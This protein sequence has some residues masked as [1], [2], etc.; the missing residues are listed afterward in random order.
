VPAESVLTAQTSYN[1]LARTILVHRAESLLLQAYRNWLGDD[2]DKRLKVKTGLTDYY[3][4]REDGAE[5]LEAKGSADH[6]HVRQALAQLLD[7]RR[8]SE[9]PVARLS[10]LFPQRP[11]PMSIDLLHDY[12]IDC[13]YLNDRDE[14]VREAAGPQM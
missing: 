5:I 1:Q 13:V 10:A 14:F 6:V 3:I 7:Y 12:G 11:G 9:K 8:F 2:S 4:E